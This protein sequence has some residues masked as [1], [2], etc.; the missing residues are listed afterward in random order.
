MVVGL[1][2][3]SA[4]GIVVGLAV[5]S[6]AGIVVGLAV[7]SAA[8]IV[9]GVA[10]DAVAQGSATKPSAKTAARCPKRVWFMTRILKRQYPTA[11]ELQPSRPGQVA[12]IIRIGSK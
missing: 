1:A 2:A 6:A 11:S 9:V 12:S 4:V 5:A 3:A 10:A 8:G 7:K